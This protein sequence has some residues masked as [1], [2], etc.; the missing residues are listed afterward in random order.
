MTFAVAAPGGPPDPVDIVLDLAHLVHH[1]VGDTG[2]VNSA[3][4]DICADQK[5]E[6]A[7]AEL[8]QHPQAVL[9][10]LAAMH[11]VSTEATLL[12]LTANLVCELLHG[13]EDENL[14]VWRFL[15]HRPQ[16]LLEDRPLLLILALPVVVARMVHDDNLL[17]DFFSRT[18]LRRFLLSTAAIASLS[19][20][21]P[22]WPGATSAQ[23]LREL[24]DFSVPSGGEEQHLP[25]LPHPANN[26]SDVV[27]EAKVQHAVGLVEDEV[28]HLREVYRARLGEVE[29]AAGRRHDDVRAPAELVLLRPLVAP[30][31]HA[32]GA[33]A[34]GPLGG[35]EDLVRLLR[36]LHGKLPR[37]CQ[38][39]DAGDV[40]ALL[41]L[42]RPLRHVHGH[43]QKE[44][45]G[46]PAASLR[47]TNYVAAG[48]HQR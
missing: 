33:D 28:G 29:Q 43:G 40:G 4:E 1:H 24:L 11:R 13:D 25:I 48:Q 47:Q 45:E 21:D 5:A 42:R 44:R 12:Q 2:D 41:S 19:I 18:V 8:V 17:D 9:L 37:R 22:D 23:T 26:G 3:A 20:R 31:V 46:L 30:A 38:N 7:L 39:Q 36:D 32:D 16:V 35:A 14:V 10:R 27:L 34:L 6:V 15:Q